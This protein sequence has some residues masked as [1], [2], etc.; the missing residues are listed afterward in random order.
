[1]RRTSHA[2]DLE[3]ILVFHTGLNPHTDHNLDLYSRLNLVPDPD[4]G[5]DT[6]PPRDR[7]YRRDRR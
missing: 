2:H 7:G 3:L 5:Y 4:H 1:M 6:E